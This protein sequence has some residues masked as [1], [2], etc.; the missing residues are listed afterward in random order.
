L[1]EIKGGYV[2]F[3]DYENNKISTN[4]CTLNIKTI[5]LSIWAAM[6]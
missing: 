4:Q 6:S 3:D 1:H 5:F 2:E